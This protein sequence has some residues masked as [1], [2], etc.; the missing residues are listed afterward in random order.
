SAT[1]ANT[2]P[3]ISKHKDNPNITMTM[4]KPTFN[5]DNCNKWLKNLR[6]LNFI[7]IS[8][9]T[10][11]IIPPFSI[12]ISKDIHQEII[13]IY[14]PNEEKGGLMFASITKSNDEIELNIES[15][16]E[17]QNDVEN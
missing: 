14:P 10:G 4:W 3:V 17:I 9:N 13:N 1:I 6:E 8:D 16:L 7:N 5:T 15:I 11:H 2:R 12:S